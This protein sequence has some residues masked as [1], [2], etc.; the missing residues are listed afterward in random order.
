MQQQ[1]A[2]A[3]TAMKST[4]TTATS[5]T[6][7]GNDESSSSASPTV[8]EPVG[9]TAGRAVVTGV[10][11]EGVVGVTGV[12]GVVGVVGE[13]GMVTGVGVMGVVGV[14]GVIGV[15]AGVGVA[16]VVGVVGVVPQ[17]DTAAVYELGPFVVHLGVNCGRVAVPKHPTRYG[18]VLLAKY[19]Y[20]P[21][22][23]ESPTAPLHMS[24][25]LLPASTPLS[26]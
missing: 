11:V 3:T 17:E 9:T 26:R 13:I 24:S 22:Q 15:V 23:S 21:S 6:H 14:V 7:T 5:T 18:N 10:A 8:G 1:T 20:D 25:P 4:H 2:A 12:M 19:A 16:G